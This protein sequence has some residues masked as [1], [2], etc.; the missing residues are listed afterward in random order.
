M[1]SLAGVIVPSTFDI[2]VKGN[3]LRPLLQQVAVG[4]Q[5]EQAIRGDRDELE[6]HAAL[7]CQHLPGDEVGMMLHLGQ[8]HQIA[9]R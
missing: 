4:V 9:R 8:D 6:P 2:W 7:R 3:Q 1:I 5:V